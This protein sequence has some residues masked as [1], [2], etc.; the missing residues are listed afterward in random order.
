VL[1]NFQCLNTEG[2]IGGIVEAYIVGVHGGLVYLLNSRE[3]SLNKPNKPNKPKERD[4][5]RL[6]IG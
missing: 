2:V 6:I 1:P 3:K 4:S 5:K